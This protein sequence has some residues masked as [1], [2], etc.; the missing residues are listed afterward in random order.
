MSLR[1]DVNMM[2]SSA[3]GTDGGID[4]NDLEAVKYVFR[5]VRSDLTARHSTGLLPVLD[6]PFDHELIAAVQNY[7]GEVKQNFDD[8]VLLG[9]GGSALGPIALHAALNHPQHNLLPADKR[10]GLRFFCPDNV[11]PDLIG[12][13]LDVA[14][15]H[16]TLYNVVSKSG[17]TAETVAQFLLIVDLLQKVLGRSWKEHLVLTTDPEKGLLREFASKE[18]IAVFPIHP[19]VG[20]RF[21][22]LTPV[23]LLPAALT[24]VDITTLCSGARAVNDVCF[25]PE[26][27]QNPAALIAACLYIAQAVKNKPIHVVFAYSNR[28]YYIADWFRQLWAESLGKRFNVDGKEIFTGPTPV[29]A[30]GATDQHSQVQLYVE[31][32]PDKAF[33]ILGTR[34]FGRELAIP[35]IHLDAPAVAYLQGADMGDLLN[36][37]R[38]ATAYALARAGRPVMTLELDAIDAR[39]IGALMNIL[40]IATLYA[41]GFY[42]VN[43]LDQPGVEAGKLATYALMNRPGY[44]AQ[45]V[46][47]DSFY[48][49]R[50]GK[51]LVVH[52]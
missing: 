4:A 51:T 32:P 49:Q 19:G 9:I 25:K 28:L 41:G 15:P 33:L 1:L 11:D 34:R 7:A 17:G 21:S 30:V 13:V 42:R 29:K 37:E 8:F 6:L 10:K 22:L 43:P 36:A 31:G 20:G 26:L 47:M 24:G 44:E 16:A 12:A 35:D 27:E 48:Q 38:R 52:I 45:K 40:E 2:L 5:A 46:E 23:G 3:I 39:H 14:N 50:C 18:G